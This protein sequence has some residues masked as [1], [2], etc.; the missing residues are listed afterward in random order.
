MEWTVLDWNRLAIDF[1]KKLGATHMKEW[2]LYRLVRP[3]MEN[4]LRTTSVEP[5]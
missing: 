3:D 5:G 1:Y 2:N 4:L